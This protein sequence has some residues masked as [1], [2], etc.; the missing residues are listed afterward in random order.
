[1]KCSACRYP[2]KMNSLGTT[3]PRGNC[4]GINLKFE[5]W[6]ATHRKEDG[7]HHHECSSVVVRVEKVAKGVRVWTAE[8]RHQTESGATLAAGMVAQPTI[9]TTSVCTGRTHR[10]LDEKV[11][12]RVRRP[13]KHFGEIGHGS[14]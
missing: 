2:P 4:R 7:S 8:H 6:P 3:T 13:H 1:M 11:G 5:L 12:E 14:V 10:V 9:P